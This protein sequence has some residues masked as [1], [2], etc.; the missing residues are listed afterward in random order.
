M[1]RR[2]RR[3]KLRTIPVPNQIPFPV[4]LLGAALRHR[5]EYAL[6][7]WRLLVAAGNGQGHCRLADFRA[8]LARVGFRRTAIAEATA[9]VLKSG[10]ANRTRNG[11]GDEVLVPLSIRRMLERYGLTG[12]T[13]R[14]DVAAGDL[15]GPGLR[16]RLLA[17]VEAGLG[18]APISREVLGEITGVSRSTQIR[19]ERDA[20][21]VVRPNLVRLEAG[22]AS[23][24]VPCTRHGDDDCRRR[25]FQAKG[26]THYQ[27]ANSVAYP[28]VPRRKRRV[29]ADPMRAAGPAGGTR[30]SRTLSRSRGA[31]ANRGKR[32]HATAKKARR[33]GSRRWVAP[34]GTRREE[35]ALAFEGT[36]VVRGRKVNVWGTV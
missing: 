20:G 19:G 36:A 14:V 32:Y 5:E 12:S 10:M 4:E 34:D 2:A 22:E 18:D 31:A 21:A 17:Y 16:R 33:Q 6:R 1:L 13:W 29:S 35:P 24:F 28:H 8:F 23:A 30:A 9:S 3:P 11:H 25:T 27:T 7:D 15:K 26:C